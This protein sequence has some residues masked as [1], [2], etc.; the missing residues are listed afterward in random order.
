MLKKEEFASK[1]LK[2]G[3]KYAQLKEKIDALYPKAREKDFTGPEMTQLIEAVDKYNAG[4]VRNKM[5]RYAK[6]SADYYDDLRQEMAVV[7][8]KET[9]KSFAR[10][11][12]QE[13]FAA[14]SRGAYYRRCVSLIEKRILEMN[15]TP[16]EE[17]R[18][19]NKEDRGNENE[20]NAADYDENLKDQNP[21]VYPEKKL[22]MSEHLLS[23][24]AINLLLLHVFVNLDDLPQKLLSMAYVRM[25]PHT[26]SERKLKTINAVTE[27]KEKIGIKKISEMTEEAQGW[28][29]EMDAEL[30]WPDAYYSEL[31]K[32]YCSNTTE[33]GKVLKNVQ[34]LPEFEEKLYDWPDAVAKKM[35]L[36]ARK[37]LHKNRELRSRC[38]DALDEI[39]YAEKWFAKKEYI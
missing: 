14:Y 20:K 18:K 28:M 32:I 8:M 36:E 7:I 12:N 11:E 15:Y 30:S 31:E 5:L 19:P 9:V 1:R 10:A 4:I 16:Y 34:Y 23:V 35:I 24:R 27:A 26:E 22:A 29:W 37:E 6:L 13:S 38:L 3:T 17:I 33:N 21:A 25:M 39:G 2:D